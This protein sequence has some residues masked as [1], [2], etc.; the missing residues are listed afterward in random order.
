MRSRLFSFIVAVLCLLAS[1]LSF[2]GGRSSRQSKIHHDPFG[3][4]SQP[5]AGRTSPF[6]QLESL[7]FLVAGVY[8]LFIAG[9]SDDDSDGDDGE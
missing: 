4:T 1:A 7:G 5:S 9:G 2:V 8:L 3:G 6:A